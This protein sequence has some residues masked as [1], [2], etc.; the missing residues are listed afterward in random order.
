MKK[1]DLKKVAKDAIKA[2]ISVIIGALFGSCTVYH[3]GITKVDLPDSC[4]VNSVDSSVKSFTTYMDSVVST[5][6]FSEPC[7]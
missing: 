6:K 3:L 5:Y 2:A 4:F 7:K 1:I